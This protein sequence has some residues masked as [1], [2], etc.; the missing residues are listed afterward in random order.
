MIV[1][2][3]GTS[4]EAIKVAP[5]ARLL[6]SRGIEYQQWLT[7]QHGRSLVQLSNDL[8]FTG[9]VVEVPNGNDGE[10]LKN[11]GSAVKWLGAVMW[12]FFRHRRRLGRSVGK[13]SLFVVHGDTL[14]TVVGAIFA[15]I[16]GVPS[17]HI[18]AG[19]RSGDWRNPFPEELDRIITGRLASIHYVPSE[20]A[21][22]NLGGRNNVVFT[23]G[24]T[25]ID[26]V[27]NSTIA[28]SQK[29]SNYGVCLL[30]RFELLSNP[31]FVKETLER[32]ARTSPVKVRL[33]LDKFSS[34]V[35]LEMLTEEIRAVIHPEPKLSHA[36]FIELLRAADFVV[37][38]SGGIQEECAEI[39]VPTLI[40]RKATERFDGIGEN[41]KLSNWVLDDVE[42]FMSSFGAL[43]RPPKKPII[44]PSQI[45]F[46]DLEARGFIRGPVV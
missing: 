32:I 45:I 17:A 9:L 19:L 18:E 30:H 34:G 37:T 39:G 15:R 6:S 40:H 13:D 8:G 10:A 43:R 11:I 23:Q 14:T 31:E 27:H 21:M 38:D 33:I 20:E 3:Y 4:A 28:K 25:V 1:F 36:K 22:S 26:A 29:V 24:N 2:V 5:L 41:V 44:S 7:M 12:W 16:L 42:K 46:E 35:I